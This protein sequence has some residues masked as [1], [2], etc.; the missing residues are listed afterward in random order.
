MFC[1]RCW[2]EIPGDSAFCAYCGIPIPPGMRDLDWEEAQRLQEQAAAT[3]PGGALEKRAATYT[4]AQGDNCVVPGAQRKQCLRCH[5]EMPSS[6]IED[7]C[8]ICTMRREQE[9][10]KRGD[11]VREQLPRYPEVKP[12]E[13]SEWQKEARAGADWDNTPRKTAGAKQTK[14]VVVILLIIFAFIV[15]VL[16]AVS[17]IFG[18][19]MFRVGNVIDSVGTPEAEVQAADVEAY[20]EQYADLEEEAYVEIPWE[21][22][23][24]IEKD[25]SNADFQEVLLPLLPQTLSEGMEIMTE[26]VTEFELDGEMLEWYSNGPVNRVK[27]V[28]ICRVDDIEEPLQFDLIATV[29]N[30]SEGPYLICFGLDITGIDIIDQTWGLNSDGIINQDG[31]E[32]WEMTREAYLEKAVVLE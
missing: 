31:E 13:R 10:A 2:R 19:L 9:E 21:V 23:D 5:K 27:G 18:N 6:A 15:F 24:W 25:S 16:P 12:P 4:N 29:C 30:D 28:A 22:Y 14:R 8:A 20:D 17:A 11:A 7:Y 26:L 32:Y 3:K 1:Q